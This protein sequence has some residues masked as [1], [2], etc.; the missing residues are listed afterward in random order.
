MSL[1][2]VVSFTPA[3]LP[4]PVVMPWTLSLH[5][6]K[7]SPTST[8][9]FALTSHLSALTSHLSRSLILIPPFQEFFDLD[10]STETLLNTRLM[11]LLPFSANL[12][13]VLPL[14]SQSLSQ[15]FSTPV[16]PLLSTS[17]PWQNPSPVKRNSAHS[18]PA[19]GQLTVAGAVHPTLTAPHCPSTKMSP[20]QRRRRGWQGR[21]DRGRTGEGGRERITLLRQHPPAPFLCPL[22]HET[23]S[24]TCL[25]SAIT[26]SCYLFHD[27]EL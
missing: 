13:S 5:T 25:F 24:K 3:Q 8:P 14:Y 20:F 1:P 12:D 26:F 4:S 11:S 19:T 17:L 15:S 23:P 16:P 22:C 2:K 10:S 21:K 9:L 6:S 27:Y 7:I 18:A